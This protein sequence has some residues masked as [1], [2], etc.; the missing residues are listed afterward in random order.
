[1]EEIS[2][3]RKYRYLEQS[4]ID[5]IKEE[6]EK[7]P[8]SMEGFAHL[9]TIIDHYVR[10]NERADGEYEAL[11]TLVTT[12][13]VMQSNQM[14]YDQNVSATY[15]LLSAIA[16]YDYLMTTGVISPEDLRQFKANGFGI[17]PDSGIPQA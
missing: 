13:D 8:E 2:T 12:L 15:P 17:I 11:F 1:M 7:M 16:F 3:D 10:V 4:Q 5:H 9:L 6:L 14:D